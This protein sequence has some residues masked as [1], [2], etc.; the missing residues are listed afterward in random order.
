M[1]APSYATNLTD[2]ITD[3]PNTTGWTLYSGGGGGANSLTAP[4]T[5]DYIQGGASPSCISRNP[6]TS[7]NY[8][9][10]TYNSSQTITAGEAVWIWVKSDVTQALTSRASGGIRVWIGSSSGNFYE[11]YVDGNDTAVKGGW[12]C[13][14]I[15]PR[16]G[17]V[18]PSGTI[19]SPTT[20]KA[21]FGAGWSVATSGPSKGFPYKIDAIRKG[22]SVTVTA[23]DSGTPATWVA[24]AAHSDGL[25]RR[26]GIVEGTATGA[27]LKGKVNWGSASAGVYS[28]DA[29]KSVSLEPTLFVVSTFKEIK[30]QHASTDL[31]WDNITFVSL[32]TTAKGQ[33]VVDSATNPKAWITNS[34]FADIDT[35][36]G[37]GTNTKFDGTTWRRCNTVTY[38]GGSYL[39]CNF[40]VPTVTAGTGALIWNQNVDPSGKLNGSSFSKGTNAHHAITFGTSSPLT[41]TL[42]GIDFSG[43][44]AADGQNDSAL[45][46]LRTTGT[47]TVNLVNCTGT[48]K[49]KKEAGATVNLV[50]S[51]TLTLT[52]LKN[53]TEV[54][55]FN[56]GT[57]TEITGQ[58]AVTT[59]TYTTG[60]DS[61]TYPSV[62]IAVL[63]LG[64][65]NLRIL[66]VSM[67]TD[68]N[69][70]VAQVIDRQYSNP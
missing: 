64:Y 45:R 27:S 56:A 13:Y 31:E 12:I 21:E 19:G 51:N 52:G 66:G 40:L 67:T 47:I 5:D 42:N 69:I 15:D 1:A 29:N 28:R 32:G 24:L 36:T 61:A 9:G 55:V 20:A 54:R 34:N 41:I 6:W 35:T 57:T 39:N 25:A 8:R 7:A 48:I 60:I 49:V 23:G 44:N 14:P 4:E 68:Q 53:P 10:M 38:N 26:W 18:T 30:I 62:D 37:G 16:N 33:F 2:I 46:F 65:Q 17:T 22:D 70:P 50:S 58:E 11:Y 43:F 63:S 3:M 59:G